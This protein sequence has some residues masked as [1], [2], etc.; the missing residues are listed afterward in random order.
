ETV[1]AVESLKNQRL[2]PTIG[3][4]EPENKVSGQVSPEILEF[5]GNHLLITN[6]GF[7][8][9]NAALILAGK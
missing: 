6:S 1:I 2:P 7:G 4:K 5:S 9:V 8:G 3:L